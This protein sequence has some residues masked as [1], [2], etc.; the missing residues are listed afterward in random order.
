MEK[1]IIELENKEK[2]S[3]SSDKVSRDFDEKLTSNSKKVE[4]CKI[5]NINIHIILN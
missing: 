1:A 3:S 5:Y 4:H 2:T